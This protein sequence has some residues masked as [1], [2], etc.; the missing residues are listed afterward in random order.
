MSENEQPAAHLATW[1]DLQDRLVVNF[2]VDRPGGGTL[3]IQLRELSFT[4]WLE[5]EFE[6][7]MPQAVP[8]GINPRTGMPTYNTSDPAYIKAATE[9]LSSR[10]YARLIKSLQVAVPGETLKE[11]IEALGNAVGASLI[12]TLEAAVNDMHGVG[13]A[14]VADHADSFQPDG[15]GPA[16]GD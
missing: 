9:C 8:N 15:A 6:F 5:P 11:K 7:P 12:R 3:V 16:D 13:R 2:E 4:E 10:T 1:E 14:R